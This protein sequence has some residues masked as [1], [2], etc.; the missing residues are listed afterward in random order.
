LEA[1]AKR[2]MAAF[3]GLE[4]TTLARLQQHHTRPS[5]KS[6]DFRM[7][8]SESHWSRDSESRSRRIFLAD[9]GMSTISMQSSC[10]CFFLLFF[11]PLSNYLQLDVYGTE[12]T[13]ADGQFPKPSDT[14]RDPECG[15]G[16]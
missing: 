1:E 13:Q 9:D 3:S 11:P 12:T 7:G 4:V 8:S 6:V 16:G 10:V 15:S 5:L 2:L 14:S